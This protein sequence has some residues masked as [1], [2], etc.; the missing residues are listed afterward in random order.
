M[1]RTRLQKTLN[2]G[3]NPTA[4]TR[5]K[6]GPTFW[7]SST[8]GYFPSKCFR[9]SRHLA[10]LNVQV[11]TIVHETYIFWYTWRK[12]WYTCVWKTLYLI[13]TLHC[14]RRNSSPAI[15]TSWPQPWSRGQASA[16]DWR[17]TPSELCDFHSQS[18]G[19]CWYVRAAA[20]T[21]SAQIRGRVISL[22][23]ER[24]LLD[25]FGVRIWQWIYGEFIWLPGIW[26]H[27]RNHRAISWR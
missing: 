11:S 25:P 5:P 8:L 7:H 27:D 20:E 17:N 4:R 14:Q 13:F 6:H 16:Y 1:Y 19:R 3:R 23:R 10:S 24:E 26:H 22:P 15:S 12:S 9:Q 18:Q 2:T 21:L